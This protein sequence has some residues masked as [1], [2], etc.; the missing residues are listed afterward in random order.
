MIKIVTE[1]DPQTFLMTSIKKAIFLIIY[2]KLQ[3][4]IDTSREQT[5]TR[6]FTKRGPDFQLSSHFNPMGRKKFVQAHLID[7][8][9]DLRVGTYAFI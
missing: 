8:L 1:S 5:V 6:Y 7:A 4:V 3:H 9:T 2:Y